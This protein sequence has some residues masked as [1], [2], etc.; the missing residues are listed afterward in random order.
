MA[1]NAFC[2]TPAAVGYLAQASLALAMTLHLALVR[3]PADRPDSRSSLNLL[4][5]FLGSAA[6]LTT[7]LFLDAALRPPARFYALFLQSTATA[8]CVTFC[9]Q[10][11]YRFPTAHRAWRI[12]SR[13]ALALAL[14]YVAYEAGFTV[15]RFMALRERSV[16][17]RPPAADLPLVIQTFWLLVVLLRQTLRA[18]GPEDVRPAWQRVWAA[19]REEARVARAA[20]GICACLVLLTIVN[21]LVAFAHFDPRVNQCALSLGV[22]VALFLLGQ[23]SL[24]HYPEQAPLLLRFTSLAWL[25]CLVLL[26]V[27]A[28]VI[29]T[30][31]TERFHRL[32]PLQSG[33]DWRFEPVGS[34]Y[35]ATQG[36]EAPEPD[37]G[38][39]LELQDGHARAVTL[40]FPFPFY[41]RTWTEAWISDNGVI[42]FGSNPVSQDLTLPYGTVPMIA[43]AL[44]DLRPGSPP[45]SADARAGQAYWRATP[46]GVVITWYRMAFAVEP[47]M[48]I[49]AQ[50]R[51]TP[52]G[53]ITLRGAPVRKLPAYDVEDALRSLWVRGLVPGNTE[54]P[55]QIGWPGD[56]PCVTAG[57]QAL[58]ADAYWDYRGV[59]HMLLAPLL[60]LVPL[61]SLAIFLAF[62]VFLRAHVTRPLRA[63]LAGVTGV[64][65]GQFS[66]PVPVYFKDDL[67]FL[68]ASFNTM[69]ANL[70][71]ARE[72]L[73]R[74][75][76]ELE[77]RVRT[78]T[79]ELAEANRQLEREV[80]ERRQ[81]QADLQ[82]AKELAENRSAAAEA[83][84]RAKSAFLANMSHEIRTPM[85]G[86]IGMTDLLLQSELT[87]DQREFATTVRQS[88]ESLLTVIDGILDLSRI[89]AGRLQ[90]E[91]VPFDLEFT[92]EQTIESFALLAENR[93]L[94]L[95]FHFAPDL[96]RRVV[97]DPGRLRQVLTNLLGNALKF[98]EAGEVEVRAELIAATPARLEARF[99]VRDT[100][101]GIPPDVVDP[102][103]QPFSQAD[104]ST[105]RR[106]GGTGLGLSI[107]KRIVR[108]MHGDIGVDPASPHGSRFWFTVQFPL[109]EAPTERPPAPPSLVGRAV[110]VVEP[111]APSR[112]SLLDLLAETGAEV[113]GAAS[114]AEARAM[115][116]DGAVPD[117]V[118]LGQPA[119]PALV[120]QAFGNASVIRLVPPTGLLSTK[121]DPGDNAAACLVKPVTRTRLRQ[122]LASLLAPPPAAT[123]NPAASATSPA[124]AMRPGHILLAEDNP[125]NQMVTIAMLQRQGCR[126]DCVAN[127]R[128]ALAALA[129]TAYDVV[130]MDVQMPE[131]D[132]LEATRRIRHPDAK[133][134]NRGIPI[135]AITAH[136]LAG[137]REKCLQAGMDAYLSKPFRMLDLIRV[138]SRWLPG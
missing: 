111:H 85:N 10:F 136:A 57:P 15:W 38:T 20:M 135:V 68:A 51:L 48:T 17:Y 98:T 30:A 106:F 95:A 12:E 102:L 11:A 23:V 101:I 3:R 9:L 124:P 97:G 83:A 108:L 37:Q 110:W 66:R 61:G 6:V 80:L 107:A 91:A 73:T 117:F 99:T 82:Q 118:V 42:G 5:W 62:P 122:C 49:T 137:E 86:V 44:A 78:R 79:S 129:R 13:L 125:V 104:S 131:L 46:D 59:M 43:V 113:R 19:R 60:L 4:T 70:R 127:G 74:A 2:I 65:A 126:V 14:A 54:P 138:L 130:L 28:W 115:R 134:L 25:S 26:A 116:A 34:G 94:A 93:G 87:R 75:N 35:R 69:V 72:E 63:L 41:G 92:V 119:A 24:N 53:R 18:A 29:T 8:V 27:S 103:F 64:N 81:A 16:L 112:Q 21:A 96:R 84:N 89:E 77:D 32:L 47:T 39:S 55:R 105:T 123:A 132:G 56:F 1:V 67:G 31:L 33:W 22:L 71:K 90:L 120:Q 40:P 88:A 52:D 100:G 133:V 7:T 128:E 76:E 36:H 109:A 58:V 50:A 121:S 114:F 45:N